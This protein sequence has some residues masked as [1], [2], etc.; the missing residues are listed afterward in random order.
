MLMCKQQKRMCKFCSVLKRLNFIV[1]DSYIKE[2]WP[3]FL[4]IMQYFNKFFYKYYLYH[5]YSD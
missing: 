3:A 1:C 4:W 2:I 5:L